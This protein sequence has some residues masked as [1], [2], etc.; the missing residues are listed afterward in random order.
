MCEPKHIE[1][2]LI[3]LRRYYMGWNVDHVVRW[4][5]DCGAVAIDKESDGRLMGTVVPMKFPKNI[6]E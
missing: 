1:K 3:T 5:P 6:K 4:C 2:D